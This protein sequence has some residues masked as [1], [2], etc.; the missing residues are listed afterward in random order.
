MVGQFL[1]QSEIKCLEVLVV[2]EHVFW[3]SAF[4]IKNRSEFSSLFLTWKPL[5][6]EVINRHQSLLAV[7][8]QEP[9]P[10]LLIKEELRNR[11]PQDKRFN[12]LRRSGE[13]P[14]VIALESRYSNRS[15]FDEIEQG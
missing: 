14:Y 2:M 7:D 3:N 5:V 11:K 10:R 9:I 6:D 13:I 12:E 1:R 4:G 8:H 15:R